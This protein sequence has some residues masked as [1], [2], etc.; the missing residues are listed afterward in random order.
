MRNKEERTLLKA[1]LSI[2]KNVLSPSQK[3][4]S[5]S[6]KKLSLLDN[7]PLDFRQQAFHC[8]TMPPSLS[9]NSLV[10]VWQQAPSLSDNRPFTS[11][12]SLVAVWQ[13]AFHF[14]KSLFQFLTTALSLSENS[15]FAF[16]KQPFRKP[17][18]QRWQTKGAAMPNRRHNDGPMKAGRGRNGVAP[19]GSSGL[20]DSSTPTPTANDN[21]DL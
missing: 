11:G 14:W 6:E 8:L 20:S 4:F 1:V 17:K 19:A 13:Q 5:L 7:R 10:T 2:L 21:R 15:L 3:A 18:A 16:Q 12:N 9:G